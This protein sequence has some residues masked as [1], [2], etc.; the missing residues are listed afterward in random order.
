MHVR[1]YSEKCA[2]N[3]VHRASAAKLV[4]TSTPGIFERG[5]SY[6]VRFYDQEGKQ[7]QRTASSLSDAKVLKTLLSGD[8]ARGDY[9][10]ETRATFAAFAA[11]WIATYDGRTARGI[12]PGTLNAYRDALG[13]D[14]D[15]KPTGRGA[16]AYFG[17]TRLTAVRARELKL[18]ARHLASQG[19]ARNTIRIALAPIKAML[20]TASEEGLIRSNPAAGLRLGRLEG[21]APARPGRALSEEELMRVLAEIP[22]I[23]RPVV[24]LLAQTGLRVSEALPLTKADVDFDRRR[25]RIVKRLYNGGLDAPKSKNGVREVSLSPQMAGRLWERLGT[26]PDDALLFEA[27]HGGPID[28]SRLYRVVRGAGRRAGID[29]PVGLHTLRHTAASI[30]WRRGVDREQIRRLLGHHSW[31]F[32]AFTYIHVGEH[33]IPDGSVL[34]DLIATP[35]SHDLTTSELVPSAPDPPGSAFLR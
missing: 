2:G 1:A 33:D 21:A 8:V 4:R 20:A 6:V 34:G 3:G 23:Y 27:V 19:L 29:W 26:A 24:E 32:T 12:R 17:R 10:A 9:L 5:S 15:G 18:Y 22:E 30:M 25:I 14:A 7:R 31:D 28:R 13:L 16:I 35:T 11:E